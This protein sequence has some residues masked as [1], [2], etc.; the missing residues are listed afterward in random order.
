MYHIHT[1]PSKGN[2]IVASTSEPV[3]AVACALQ[4]GEDSTIQADKW[5]ELENGHKQKTSI[6][7]WICPLI[8]SHDE[9]PDPS[10][11]A[12]HLQAL[13]RRNLCVILP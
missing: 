2:K 12:H 6:V 4:L 10:T 8:E 13:A 9:T 3:L 7:L 1:S 5:V 11:V